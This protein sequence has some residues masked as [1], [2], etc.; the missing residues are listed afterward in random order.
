MPL[1]QVIFI[2]YPYRN[3][4]FRKLNAVTKWRKRLHLK[5][6]SKVNV[7]S[8]CNGGRIKWAELYWNYT[9]TDLNRSL[10]KQDI[11]ENK[12]KLVVWKLFVL[13]TTCIPIPPT[14]FLYISEFHS[15]WIKKKKKSG[16]EIKYLA[17]NFWFSL[18]STLDEVGWLLPIKITNL[19]PHS[20][21]FSSWLE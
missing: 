2:S 11:A 21:E 14:A 5:Q 15:I 7:R 17:R 18:F 16:S 20:T 6:F 13:C 19:C 8:S 10:R 12:V 4:S 1:E 3:K 9:P